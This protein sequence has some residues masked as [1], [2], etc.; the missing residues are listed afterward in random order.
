MKNNQCIFWPNE[1][2]AKQCRRKNGHGPHNF[3]CKKHA[4]RFEI[5]EIIKNPWCSG[6]WI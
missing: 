4:K 5:L 3:Y 2:K 1:P 6:V